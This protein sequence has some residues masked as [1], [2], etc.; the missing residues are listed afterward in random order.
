MKKLII[1]SLVI[2][3]TGLIAFYVI[4]SRA[5]VKEF[6]N[7]EI[8]TPSVSLPTISDD[9]K[10]DVKAKDGKKAVDIKITGI[11]SDIETIE[12][13]LIYQTGL[14]LSRGVNGKRRVQDLPIEN[15]T[16]GSCSTGGKCTYDEGVSE[17]DLVLKF[18]AP[19]GSSIY[20]KTF[21]I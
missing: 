13:E 20:R 17:I 14:G 15:I 3:T 10:V 16:L 19:N 1:I 11:P 4:N 2:I 6:T 18:N 5:K 8:P 12:Y 21:P 9:V 7:E